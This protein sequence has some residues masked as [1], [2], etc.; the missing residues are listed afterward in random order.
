ML[1]I[2]TSK[3]YKLSLSFIFLHMFIYIILEEY[4]ESASLLFK[5]YSKKERE[6]KI[7]RYTYKILL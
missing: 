4:R 6:K 5:E 1:M 7:K 2:Y 3:I